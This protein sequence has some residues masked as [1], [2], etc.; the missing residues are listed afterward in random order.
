MSGHRQEHVSVFLGD[1][2]D[3]FLIQGL[4][5]ASHGI[6]LIDLLSLSRRPAEEEVTHGSFSYGEYEGEMKILRGG[7]EKNGRAQMWGTR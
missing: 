7:R 1:V 6:T 2:R 3:N 5:G 4:V